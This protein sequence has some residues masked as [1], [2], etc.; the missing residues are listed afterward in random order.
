M[1]IMWVLLSSLLILGWSF[2]QCFGDHLNEDKQALLDFIHGVKHLRSPNWD[3]NSPV[4][5]GN[6][7]GVGCNSDQTRVI[8]LRL[9]GIGLEGTIPSNTLARLSALQILSLRSNV[10]FGPFPPDLANLGNLTTLYLQS[11]TF[12]GPLLQN[13]S[14]LGSLVVLN[15]SYNDFNGTIP[16]SLLSNL[17]HL[18]T[19][20]LS[21]NSLSGQIPPDI[22]IIT[23]LTSLNLSYNNLT[24]V[25]PPSLDRFPTSAFSGNSVSFSGLSPAPS[26]AFPPTEAKKSSSNVPLGGTALLGV[27]LGACVLAFLVIAVVMIACC[28]SSQSQEAGDHTDNAA[29]IVKKKSVVVKKK[30]KTPYQDPD[31]SEDVNGR[32][33]FFE[34]S[35]LAAFDLEDLLRASAEVLGKGIF[36]TTY[37]ASLEDSTTVVVKRLKQV[38]VGKHEFVQQMEIVGNVKHENVAPLRAYYYSKDEKL[39]VYDYFIQGSVSTMLHMN[40]RG[41]GGGENR[42]NPMGLDW[43]TRLRI[44]IGAARGIA[45]IHTE[46]GGKLVHGNIKASNIFLNSESYGSISDLGLATIVSPPVPPI[47]RAPGYRAPEVTDPR[48][49]SQAS[50][51]YSFGVLLLELLTGKSPAG[52]SVNLVKWVHSV[53]REEWTAEVFDADLLKYSNIEEQMVEMLQLGIACAAR[54]PDQR[55]KMSEAVRLVEAI[56]RYNTGNCPSEGST[57][58]PPMSHL[59]EI[60]ST[61]AQT[62]Q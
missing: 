23:S 32:I 31:S 16:S 33:T 55:P 62:Q 45:H 13:F 52:E 30:K 54:V 24:G 2:L 6:W 40:K 4:C 41:G 11:N 28:S 46:N 50:D 19:L 42:K 44:A 21:H 15:L 39:M 14:G 36:G 18:T 20:D 57:P 10:L 51:V 26:P 61:S 49:A 43:E 17:T 5:G 1:E 22:N 48:K 34:D 3:E 47:P 60:G 56:R 58:T 59:V 25:V 35:N 12:S 37:K 53:V 7:T 8:A 27:I 38:N 29:N 9:P